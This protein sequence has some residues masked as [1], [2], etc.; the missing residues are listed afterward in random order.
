MAKKRG[1]FGSHFQ[2]SRWIG[3]KNIKHNAAS[4]RGLFNDLTKVEQPEVTETFEQAVTRLQL[5]SEDITNKTMFFLKLALL[6]LF[7]AVCIF[8]Y[9][10]L[11]YN[12]GDLIGAIMCLPIFAVLC[13]FCFREHFWYTQMKQKRL[14]ITAREWLDHLLKGG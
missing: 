9:G 12:T 6:Y 2:F 5:S 4:I 11:L 13:S 7:F 10:I 3:L 8:I 14:G 1:F